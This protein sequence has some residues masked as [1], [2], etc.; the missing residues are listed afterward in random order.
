MIAL[1]MP[2]QSRTRPPSKTLVLDTLRLTL[3]LAAVLTAPAALAD[4]VAQVRALPQASL[5]VQE[6]GRDLI[7][8]RA[9]TPRIP[10]S[11][12]KV[13]TAFAALE[14]WGRNHHFETDFYS[15]DAGWLWVRGYADP[16]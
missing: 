15:D 2:S 14:T 10:A 16:Y 1:S 7:A 5:L 4:P 12:M 13:L 8:T 6:N 11:T 9:E 3:L